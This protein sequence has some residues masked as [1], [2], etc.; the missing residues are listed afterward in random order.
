VLLITPPKPGEDIDIL[1]PHVARL[2][3]LVTRRGPV[4]L[5]VELD[6]ASAGRP[7]RFIAGSEVAIE[8]LHPLGLMHLAAKVEVDQIE[9][10]P[11]LRLEVVGEPGPVERREHTRLPIELGVRAWT[12]AQPHRR[13]PGKTLDLSVGG[14]LLSLRELSPFA[15]TVELTIDLPGKPLDVSARVAWRREPTLVG[16]EFNG[17]APEEEAR[18]AEFLRASR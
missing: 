18:L 7:F 4:S 10:K 6:H 9:P 17:I 14:A 12:L 1:A 13:L 3:G 2:R 8:W 5:T 16:V 15:A 11:M